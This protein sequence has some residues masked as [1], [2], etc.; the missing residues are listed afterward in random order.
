M[1]ISLY[2]TALKSAINFAESSALSGMG[3]PES[4]MAEHA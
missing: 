1:C 3:Y 4:N 2:K